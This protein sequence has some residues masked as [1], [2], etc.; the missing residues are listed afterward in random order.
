MVVCSYNGAR[1]IRNTL[2]HLDALEYPNYEVI[3]IRDGSTDRTAEIVSEH[4]ARL[5]STENR[6]LSSARNTGW[7][8]AKGEI[9]AYIDDDAYPDPHW[10][11]YLA[12]AFM[13]TDYVGVGG[14][15]IAPGGDGLMADCVANAP[16]GPVH[17]LL[18]NTEAEHIPGCN[19]AFRGEAL[20]SIG[21]FDPRYHAAGDDVDLCWRLQDQGWRIGFHPGAL[22]WHHR[23]NS[24]K[25]YWKQQVGYG[26][27]EAMLEDKWPWKY[28]DAGHIGWQGRL[29]GKGLTLP[30]ILKRSRVYQGTQG[31][32]LFQ[33]IYQPAAGYWASLPLMPEWWLVIG[34]LG[35]LSLLILG[36][37]KLS[38][39]I[40]LFALALLGPI[41]QASIS[42]WKSEFPTPGW[43]R[44]QVLR[45]RLI[46]TGLHLLQPIARLTGRIRHGLT[47]WRRRHSLHS[48]TPL[49]RTI[50]LWREEWTDPPKILKELK[51]KIR[52]GGCQSWVGNEYDSWDLEVRGGLLGAARVK[53]VVEEHGGGKQMYKF[54]VWPQL[55]LSLLF[56]VGIV[57]MLAALAASDN[58]WIASVLLGAAAT[59][60]L[61]RGLYETTFP[62]IAVEK[63]IASLD[64]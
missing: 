2:E 29:Y 44:G 10:L 41:V 35:L 26:K 28:N 27:A 60:I 48:A 23:R 12:H 49:P 24:V 54:R 59:G 38:F 61:F 32:A 46:T 4:D 5:I 14:P 13:T 50:T 56:S 64:S 63:A 45:M 6:G 1:T 30:I 52:E 7:Q 39:V 18:G 57:G 20:E 53:Q 58:A 25:A 42:A 3:V 55:K 8:E 17:V 33:S 9:V 37:A 15:N 34:A 40:P 21:G 22:D 19:M 31:S 36:W 16:G 43:S 62:I 11:H 51:Q 47:L